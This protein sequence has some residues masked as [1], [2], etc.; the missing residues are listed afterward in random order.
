MQGAQENCLE[1]ERRGIT[2]RSAALMDLL[3]L[4]VRIRPGPTPALWDAQV[5]GQNGP[6]RRYGGHRDLCM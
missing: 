6:G 4:R 1:S 2:K 3:S 5:L